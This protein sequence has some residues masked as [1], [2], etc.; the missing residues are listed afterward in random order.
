ME[1]VSLGEPGELEAR[2]APSAG[3]VGCSLLHRGEELL[4][5]RRGFASYVS[6]R[7]TMGIPLLYPWANR[8]SADRFTVAG[9]EVVLDAGPPA[10]T[11][12]RDPNGLPMHGLLAADPGWRVE[13][14]DGHVLRASLDF[15][16][17]PDLLA[18]FPFPH[19]LELEVGVAGPQLTIAAR[20]SANRE[21]PV[22]VS[23]GFH[24]YLKLPGVARRDWEVEIPV[25]TQLVLDERNLPTGERK[26]VRVEDGALGERTFDDG[27][28]AP[29]RGAPFVLSG[30]GRR[31]EL[32]FESG[33]DYAQVFAPPN[34]DVIAY[35]PMT[36]PTN[37]LVTG[38]SLPVIDPGER[39]EAE[40][41]L[42]VH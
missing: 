28:E 17:R 24:P 27:Y 37:A 16:G 30:G 2:F 32:G 31:I 14:A 8:L 23:F 25:R 9:R 35:E 39:Y 15:G 1:V 41:S 18:A 38:D 36:A 40:F 4:G 13:S 5:Q 26:E 33:Y 10:A 21:S 7:K 22:P 3:M 42:E 20:V 6:D 19:L 29:P 12:T 11:P 34:D